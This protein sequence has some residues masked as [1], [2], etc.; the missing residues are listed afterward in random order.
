MG[1]KKFKSPVSRLSP[2]LMKGNLVCSGNEL[3]CCVRWHTYLGVLHV[4]PAQIP[5]FVCCLDQNV[6]EVWVV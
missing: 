6:F 3:N 2:Q 4:Q 5:L 1:K